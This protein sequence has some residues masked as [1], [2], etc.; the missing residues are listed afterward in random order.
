MLSHLSVRARNMHVLF[1]TCFDPKQV[2]GW[3]QGGV[4]GINAWQGSG[5]ALSLYSDW[6]Q[7][8]SPHCDA[9][10]SKLRRQCACLAS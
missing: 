7:T 5:A 2:G 10:L 9:S 6:D 8:G 4:V 1:A 3:G